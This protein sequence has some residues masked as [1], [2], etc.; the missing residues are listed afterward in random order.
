MNVIGLISGTSI[1]GIDAALVS[2]SGSTTDLSVNLIAAHTYPY[3]E[4]LRSQIL[5][6]CGGASLSME[7]FAALD[8]AISYHFAQAALTLQASHPPARRIG[9]RGRAV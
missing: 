3:P 1:D 2:I 6:V 5:A 4:D 8:D 9:S 7:A